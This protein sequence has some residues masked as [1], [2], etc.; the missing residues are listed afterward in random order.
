MSLDYRTRNTP[1][2]PI[3]ELPGSPDNPEPGLAN[4]IDALSEAVGAY[5]H[6]DAAPSSP[7]TRRDQ[8]AAVVIK[9]VQDKYAASYRHHLAAA[10]RLLAPTAEVDEAV[11]AVT[12]TPRLQR[13]ETYEWLEAHQLRHAD[14]RLTERSIAQAQRFARSQGVAEAEQVAYRAMEAVLH[15]YLTLGSR[16][17]RAANDT[18]PSAERTLVVRQLLLAAEAELRAG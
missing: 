5:S 16:P 4:V 9:R 11:D 17:S 6:P 18:R 13:D 14:P 2:T 7:T 8:S 3:T 1:T 15:G 12:A 10:L